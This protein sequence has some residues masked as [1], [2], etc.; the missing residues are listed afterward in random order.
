MIKKA[1]FICVFAVSGLFCA[2]FAMADSLVIKDGVLYY[3]GPNSLT[4]DLATGGP[5]ACPV[6]TTFTVDGA[7][8]DSDITISGGKAFVNASGTVTSYTIP[9]G[10]LAGDSVSVG[11]CVAV[12]NLSTG[13]LTVPCVDVVGDDPD[14]IYGANFERRGNSSNWEVISAPINEKFKH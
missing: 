1:K 10:C 12:A 6:S 4:I 11:D 14:I 5:S 8:A 2:D 3:T 7:T 9:P 13:E